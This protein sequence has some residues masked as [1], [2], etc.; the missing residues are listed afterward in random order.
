MT[1]VGRRKEFQERVTL[2]LAEGTCGRIDAVL[3]DDEARVAMIRQAIEREI[4]RRTKASD[5]K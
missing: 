4:A 3:K 1:A 5:R 2:P